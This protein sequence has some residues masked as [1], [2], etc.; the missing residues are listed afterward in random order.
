MCAGCWTRTLIKRN[1]IHCVLCED[2]LEARTGLWS[3]GP[4]PDAVTVPAA[5]SKLIEVTTSTSVQEARK[6]D[7]TRET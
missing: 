1:H 4:L 3:E 2:K 7:T 5:P 6:F